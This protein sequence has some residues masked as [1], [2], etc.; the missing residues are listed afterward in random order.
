M[1]MRRQLRYNFIKYKFAV[2]LVQQY[3]RSDDYVPECDFCLRS[4]LKAPHNA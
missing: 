3:G 4:S 2:A 1:I